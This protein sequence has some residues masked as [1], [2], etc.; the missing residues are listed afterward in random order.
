MRRWLPAF[1][2]TL[3]AVFLVYLTHVPGSL[4]AQPAK[5]TI[6]LCD[7][8]LGKEWEPWP[9]RF[10]IPES[11]DRGWRGAKAIV[12]LLAPYSRDRP[13]LAVA[14][15]RLADSASQPDSSVS[16][17]LARL[18][19]HED[20]G[21]IESVLSALVGL[22][23][24]ETPFRALVGDLSLSPRTR[25]R[26]LAVIGTAGDDL[27]LD[28]TQQS[29]CQLT[30]WVAGSSGLGDPIRPLERL[31]TAI[32][33]DG[34]HLLIAL[35]EYAHRHEGVFLRRT[36]CVSLGTCLGPAEWVWRELARP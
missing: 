29:L 19:R 6:P 13:T 31:V 35:L 3:L 36:G 12:D 14:V 10:P 5:P 15:S 9:D 4:G 34:A 1:R 26:V 28:A 33:E 18:V 22:R 7:P 30:G 23:L 25:W 2:T 24:N 21:T 16:V 27:M 17:E 11:D 8:H 20:D 32:T